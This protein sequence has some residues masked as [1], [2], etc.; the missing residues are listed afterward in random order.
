MNAFY[1]QAKENLKKTREWAKHIAAHPFTGFREFETASFIKKELEAMGYITLS[2][3]DIPYVK[4]VLDTGR[5]GPGVCV[6]GEMDAIFLDGPVHACGHHI[7]CAAMLSCALLLK[8]HADRDN[9]CGRVI[10][11]AV[12]AE[13]HIETPYRME[14]EKQGI[15]RYP[16][17]KPELLHRGLFG[18]VDM[19]VMVHMLPQDNE[20]SMMTSANGNI[21]K[22]IIFRG[23]SAHAGN[24]PQEGIN[25]LYAANLAIN[26]INALRET[27]TEDQFA[28]VHP[29]ITKGGDV[30]NVIPSEVRM[31]AYVRASTV[32][33]MKSI[34]ARV[35][36]ALT[37]C[38]HALAAEVEIRDIPGYLPIH[39]HPLFNE[40]AMETARTVFGGEIKVLGHLGLCSDIGDMSCV[41][42]VMH[43]FV[44]GVSGTLHGE[45]FRV[46]DED[47]AYVKTGAF[48][49]SL[50]R[51]LLEKD[52]KKA[53]E[54]LMSFVPLYPDVESYFKDVDSMVSGP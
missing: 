6:I 21:I 28:R 7:S 34:N 48:L 38:A 14:L 22:E 16:S 47:I 44:G 42:P 30:V 15:I 32:E 46:S 26:A 41:M 12:P 5:E 9:L 13:E 49:A 35:N 54:L 1:Q 8:E 18:D 3:E 10:F 17:G 39:I 23:K 36:R 24:A 51:D 53:K 37:G 50:C 45:D 27:F 43:P 2:G 25:A 33:H 29:I 11:M 31:E 40:M 52:A 4:A 19:C 20:I